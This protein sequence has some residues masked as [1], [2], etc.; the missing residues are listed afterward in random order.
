MAAI[1]GKFNPE[2]ENWTNYT[3]QIEQYFKANDVVDGGKRKAILLTACG[4]VTFKNIHNII[5]ANAVETG[6]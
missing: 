4:A 5:D 2:V 3:L 6:E 1:H